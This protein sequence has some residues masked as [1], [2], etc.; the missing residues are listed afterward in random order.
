[1]SRLVM[2]RRPNETALSLVHSETVDYLIDWLVS[3]NMPIVLEDFV[4]VQFSSVIFRV[5]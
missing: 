4:G 2:S 3:W 1:M 5:V